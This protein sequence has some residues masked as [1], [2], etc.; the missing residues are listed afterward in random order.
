MVGD[1]HVW[2]SQL[3]I[4]TTSAGK[5]WHDNKAPFRPRANQSSWEK[6]SADRAALAAV[7]AKE[8]ELKEE[9]ESERQVRGDTCLRRDEG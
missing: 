2:E 7:K 5:Q 6:R 8:K 9:K 4:L 1:E 3:G